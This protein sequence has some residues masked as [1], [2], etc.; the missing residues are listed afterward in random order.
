MVFSE[1][2]RAAL[3]Y[4]RRGA[5]LPTLCTV[6]FFTMVTGAPGNECSGGGGGGGGGVGNSSSTV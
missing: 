2:R 1:A 3:D 5:G 4:G 6:S